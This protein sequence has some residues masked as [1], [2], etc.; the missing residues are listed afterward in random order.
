MS[1]I[2]NI[3][4]P[5]GHASQKPVSNT[6]TGSQTSGKPDVASPVS[7]PS[8]QADIGRESFESLLAKA[9]TALKDTP[10]IRQDVV[11]RVRE[12][13]RNGYYDRPEVVEEMAEKLAKAFRPEA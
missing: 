11:E 4:G 8:D 13:I 12:R 7:G 10:E 3:G 5:Q 2:S 1:N 9:R 6:K